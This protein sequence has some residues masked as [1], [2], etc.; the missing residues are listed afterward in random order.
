MR[1]NLGAAQ[2]ESRPVPALQVGELEKAVSR[3]RYIEWSVFPNSDNKV[4]QEEARLCVLMDIREELQKLNRLLNCG[5]FLGI[6]YSLNKIAKNTT[7]KR[8]AK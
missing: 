6:P 4:T 2:A 5:N 8:R 7:R 3:T 1:F